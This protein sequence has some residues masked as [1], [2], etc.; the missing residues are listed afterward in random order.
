MLRWKAEEVDAV[1]L[2]GEIV[3]R[4]DAREI[5][6]TETTEYVLE[7]IKN[8]GK[9]SASTLVM[10]EEGLLDDSIGP[11]I[12]EAVFD[13]KVIY[14]GDSCPIESTLFSVE[15]SD[16]SDVL[17]ATLYYR[18]ASQNASGEWLEIL[19][20]VPDEGSYTYQFTQSDLEESLV[21]ITEGK[22]EYYIE[23]MDLLV[24][25]SKTEVQNIPIQPCKTE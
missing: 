11:V 16:E 15:I 1:W 6:P 14:T 13:P 24:N 25:E 2:D 10:V 4:E 9:D 20:D 8:G 7:G 18:A 21:D 22:M 19:L 5:C 23:A 3:D 12:S 17:L